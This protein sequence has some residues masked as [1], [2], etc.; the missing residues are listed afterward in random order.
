MLWII[1]TAIKTPTYHIVWGK[2][3]SLNPASF[4]YLA[5]HCI[6]W[7]ICIRKSLR[8]GWRSSQIYRQILWLSIPRRFKVSLQPT[9]QFAW[10]KGQK[11]VNFS[12]NLKQFC[13][14]F[15]ERI[16]SRSATPCSWEYFKPL[17][18]HV[19]AFS[20][21]TQISRS[22][23]KD[24]GIEL[25]RTSVSHR[26]YRIIPRFTLQTIHLESLISVWAASCWKK[27]LSHSRVDSNIWPHF[28]L[29]CIKRKK[30]MERIYA[31]NSCKNLGGSAAGIR[32]QA[33]L[34]V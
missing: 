11:C 22:L 7:I 1:Q 8:G 17:L 12:W 6:K 26:S 30:G 34:G 13:V 14:I 32:T 25:M 16:T 27:T 18:L 2:K 21:T 15:K 33:W 3:Q 20:P 28:F 29:I 4:T 31:L 24:V 10:W 19:E 9:K 23:W 5:S